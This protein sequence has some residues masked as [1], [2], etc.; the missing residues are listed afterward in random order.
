MM[1][2]HLRQPIYQQF[3]HQQGFAG[4]VMEPLPGDASVRRY[5]RLPDADKPCLLMDMP[6]EALDIR[7]YLRV[8]EHLRCLGLRVPIVYA[9]DQEC[10]LALI[11]DFGDRTFTRL[12]AEGHSERLL[13]ELAIDQLI[14][15]HQQRTATTL[16][17]PRY[18]ISLFLREAARLPDWLYPCLTGTPITSALRAEYLD[19]WRSILHA[20]PEP[21]NSLV[22]VDFHVDNLIR[23]PDGSCGMLDFQDARIGPMAY[24]VVSLLED[25]RRDVDADIAF[26]IKTRYLNSRPAR[27][28]AAFEQWYAVLG[29]QRHC[30]VSGLFLR[31]CITAG[32][33]QYL[34]HLPRVMRLLE[35]HLQTQARLKPLHDW[36]E[37]YLPMRL[38]P[39][40]TLNREEL[41]TLLKGVD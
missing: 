20:M 41:R 18:D 16:V 32:K 37:Y 30:K 23:L 2:T 14:H 40:P 3:L 10:G 39:L 25:A 17:A 27:E 31:L 7:P 21:E 38:Q 15:L 34:V 24:D 26:D 22:L 36:L 9:V 8:A 29:A 28:R 4:T 35:Q 13:Y 11:E 1:N 33:C 5:F 19:I 12:L 6:P